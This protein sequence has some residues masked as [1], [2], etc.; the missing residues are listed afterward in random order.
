MVV[1]GGLDCLIELGPTISSYCSVSSGC[2]GILK[3]VAKEKPEQIYRDMN[4]DEPHKAYAHIL[5]WYR[6]VL[7]AIS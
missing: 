6:R 5:F 7:G 3:M 1:L 2:G 4:F